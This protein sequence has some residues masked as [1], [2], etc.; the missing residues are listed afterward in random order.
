MEQATLKNTSFKGFMLMRCYSADCKRFPKTHKAFSGQSV[1]E[2]GSMTGRKHSNGTAEAP[3]STDD[4]PQMPLRQAIY[5][6]ACERKGWRHTSVRYTKRPP[7]YSFSCL[8]R[9]KKRPLSVQKI[10]NRV[11][12][13]DARCFG[14][15]KAH[16]AKHRLAPCAF[17]LFWGLN[18]SNLGS[19]FIFKN[20]IE[21]V[22]TANLEDLTL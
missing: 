9:I 7:T 8:K 19:K 16:S 14:N 18:L 22:G 21:L 11:T 20:R 2:R 4:R 6:T 3:Y 15:Q 10:T 17:N 5:R 12:G 13:W 1:S